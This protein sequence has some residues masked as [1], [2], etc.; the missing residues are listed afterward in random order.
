MCPTL[1]IRIEYAV[2]CQLFGTRN[3]EKLKCNSPFQNARFSAARVRTKNINGELQSC[4][5]N[6]PF[7]CRRRSVWRFSVVCSCVAFV[8]FVRSMFRV[9]VFIFAKKTLLRSGEKIARHICDYAFAL[10]RTAP[11][12]FAR[13]ALALA[14][15]LCGR[16]AVGARAS[17][18]RVV[19]PVVFER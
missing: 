16:L 7:V 19:S 6:V 5:V 17:A 2:S 8:A 9:G 13:T 4:L 18:R 15:A 3:F 14:L 11:F 10:H 1:P 12:C